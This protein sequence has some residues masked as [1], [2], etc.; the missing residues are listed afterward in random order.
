MV[1]EPTKMKQHRDR[2]LDS[3]T[4]EEYEVHKKQV[5]K[6][7]WKEAMKSLKSKAKRRG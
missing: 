5:E 4:E 2:F 1:G 6:G 7:V 3:L